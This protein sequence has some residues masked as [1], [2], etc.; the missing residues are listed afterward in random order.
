MGRPSKL[1][2]ATTLKIT[3]AIRSGTFSHIAAQAAGISP[4]TFFDWLSKGRNGDPQFSE[5]SEEVDRA[6]AEARVD[7]E[8]R[9]FST[10]PKSWLRLGPGR[11]DSEGPGWTESIESGSSISEQLDQLAPDEF[12]TLVADQ[13]VDYINQGDVSRLEDEELEFSIWL[14]LRERGIEIQELTELMT[15]DSPQITVR[16]DGTIEI[17]LV[18]INPNDKLTRA[19][20]SEGLSSP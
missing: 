13:Y 16:G 10:D 9:V 18:K 7:A 14:G 15:P 12:V 2:T 5:F 20:L 19:K 17:G 11:S 8:M 3:V 6:R 4:S 1:T